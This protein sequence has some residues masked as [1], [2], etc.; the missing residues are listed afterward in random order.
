MPSMRVCIDARLVA[1]LA[2]FLGGSMTGRE[3]LLA[4]LESR[5]KQAFAA[6]DPSPVL[7]LDAVDEAR[8]L[9]VTLSRDHG[10]VP[11][12]YLLG[13]LHW[14]RY[15]ALPQDRGGADLAAAIVMFSVCFNEGVDDVPDELKPTLAE[16]A[17]PSAGMLL[18]AVL[19][20][21]DTDL[22]AVAASCGSASWKPPPPMTL[23]GPGA[24][25]T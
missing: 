15:R 25:I 10:D 5:L 18:D 14:V 13:W 21:A 16:L 12:R 1:L 9:T 8:Q 22:A 11:A 6:R 2:W 7:E 19:D 24:S 23:A 17:I 3:E 4:D 20:S